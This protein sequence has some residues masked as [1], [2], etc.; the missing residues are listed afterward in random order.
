VKALSIWQPWASL[1]AVGAKTFETRGW[2]APDSLMWERF[3]ICAAKTRRGIKIAWSDY[4]LCSL[5]AQFLGRD[6]H[7]PGRLPLGAVVATTV[8]CE[9]ILCPVLES[10]EPG[11]RE[12]TMGDWSDG[13]W[14]WSLGDTYR[15]ERP[16][17]VRGQQ[18]LFDLP[19]DTAAAMST[20]ICVR[21]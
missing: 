21:P 14:A 15:L 18:G 1:I 5:C 2:Q 10:E 3:A 11:P 13:R 19:P 20:A 6:W 16:V 9:R 17:A 8:L 7:M 12:R 4:R